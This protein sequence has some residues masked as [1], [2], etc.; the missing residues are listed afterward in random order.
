MSLNRPRRRVRVRIGSVLGLVIC[1]SSQYS[2]RRTSTGG[3][4]HGRHHLLGRP[5]NGRR[6][7]RHRLRKEHHGAHPRRHEARV[8][9]SPAGRRWSVAGDPYVH[10]VSQGR[11]GAAGGYAVP[12]GAA[13]LRRRTRRLPGHRLKR[14]HKRR[15]VPSCGA[16]RRVRRDRVDR[17]AGLVR[18]QGRHDRRLVRR[19]LERAGR[20]PGAASP[21]HDHPLELHRRQVHGR[22]PLPRRRLA[23][24]LRHRRVRM[25]DDRHELDAALP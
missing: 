15:R 23:L 24:L 7:G 19:V 12:L 9:H 4:E 18:R 16:P 25:L 5:A 11:P 6:R 17:R 21:G 2:G 14:G 8:G 20:R 1:A 13:R 22:L 10:P 3:N